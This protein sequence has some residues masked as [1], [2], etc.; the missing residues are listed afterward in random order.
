MFSVSVKAELETIVGDIYVH[1]IWLIRMHSRARYT[2]RT[3]DVLDYCVCSLMHI[4]ICCFGNETAAD[5]FY[6]EVR[7]TMVKILLRSCRPKWLPSE[8]KTPKAKENVW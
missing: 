5:T 2:L 8:E 6:L 7:I 3:H 1:S 4:V